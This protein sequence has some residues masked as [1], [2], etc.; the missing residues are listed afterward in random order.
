MRTA[1]VAL[2]ALVAVVHAA[3]EIEIPKTK[4]GVLAPGVA[5]KIAT[6]G[7][8]PTIRVLD[9]GS[10]AKSELVYSLTKGQSRKMA[11]VMDMAMTIGMMGQKQSVTIPQ[12]TLVFEIATVDKNNKGEFQVDATVTSTEVK[13]GDAMATKLREEIAKMRGVKM[14]YWVDPKGYIHDGKVDLPKDMP[15]QMKQM[16]GSMT[17]SL[18]SLSMPLPADAIGVGGKWQGVTRIT[19]NGADILQSAVHTLKSRT[20]KT[21]TL[22]VSLRQVAASDT[23]AS[24]GISSKVKQF[25]SSGDGQVELDLTT[26]MPN[27][28][29]MHLKMG[30]DIDAGGS[31]AHMDM[32]MTIGVKRP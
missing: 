7:T 18:Q 3:P 6:A 27:S 20:A 5:D 15:E 25:D 1:L 8:K 17:Q 10:G 19:S 31:S 21:A 13:G 30:M 29:T 12:M 23:I 11:M 28:A 2:V 22:D 9:T 16:M 24:N 4:T 14:T 32:T 26:G